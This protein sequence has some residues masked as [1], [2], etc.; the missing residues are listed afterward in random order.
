MES[1]PPIL[2]ESLPT[3]WRTFSKQTQVIVR[4]RDAHIMAWRSW[5]KLRLDIDWCLKFKC[6]DTRRLD[7]LDHDGEHSI[8]GRRR[9]CGLRTAVLTNASIVSRAPKSWMQRSSV[10]AERPV[11]VAR[12]F[13]RGCWN[14]GNAYGYVDYEKLQMPGHHER[15]GTGPEPST[16]GWCT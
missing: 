14:S 12:A 3:L 4:I 8:K 15:N 10:A 13:W 6:Y 5:T 7:S 2:G 11:G 16:W 9:I 1:V